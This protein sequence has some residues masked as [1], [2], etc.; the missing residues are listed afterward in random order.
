MIL[1]N[2]MLNIHEFNNL[3]TV[4]LKEN[5]CIKNKFKIMTI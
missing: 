1:S 4:L 3:I 2:C 5:K